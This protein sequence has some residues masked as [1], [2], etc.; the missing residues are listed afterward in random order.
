[1]LPAIPAS[2]A[3]IG[4]TD[5]PV[6]IKTDGLTG[7]KGVTVAAID[8]ALTT[9]IFGDTDSSVVVEE[10]GDHILVDGVLPLVTAQD[11]KRAGAA[12]AGPITGGMGCYSPVPV[13]SAETETHIL[14]SIIRPTI[15]EMA[16]HPLP[17]HPPCRTET[18]GIQR[19]LRG[20]GMPGSDGAPQ[21]GSRACAAGNP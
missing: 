20:S 6:V 12:D 2:R 16:W 13:V 18:P 14:G 3:W 8:N 21:V 4:G 11:H 17:R 1:M 5:A 15:A 19:S 9:G 10:A 7:G